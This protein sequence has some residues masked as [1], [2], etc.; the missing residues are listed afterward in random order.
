MSRSTWKTA[1]AVRRQSCGCATTVTVMT[2]SE[3]SDCGSDRSSIFDRL[4]AKLLGITEQEDP[5]VEDESSSWMGD[6]AGSSWR[7]RQVCQEMGPIQGLEKG[8]P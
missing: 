2:D 8:R 4:M 7:Q 3:E 1:D 6:L 5:Q